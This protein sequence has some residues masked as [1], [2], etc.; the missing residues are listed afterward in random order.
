MVAVVRC[1]IRAAGAAKNM[2]KA[3][4]CVRFISDSSQSGKGTSWTLGYSRSVAKAA[5]H[6][7]APVILP[8]RPS[9]E[10]S[11]VDSEFDSGRVANQVGGAARP[12]GDRKR[13]PGGAPGIEAQQA[14]P[15]AWTRLACYL[16]C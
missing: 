16:D 7:T 2:E 6:D 4:Y 15:G 13:P 1:A 5:R 11:S 10:P 8:V 12:P 9:R 3:I 14:R